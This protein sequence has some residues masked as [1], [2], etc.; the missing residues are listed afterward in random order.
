M[1]GPPLLNDIRNQS[2]SKQHM[3]SLTGLRLKTTPHDSRQRVIQHSVT[4]NL[5][6]CYYQTYSISSPL[7]LP[8]Y[9]RVKYKPI[10]L[11]RMNGKL[12]SHRSL[13]FREMLYDGTRIPS[14]WVD[15]V[16]GMRENFTVRMIDGGATRKRLR[17]VG[18]GVENRIEEFFGAPFLSVA[19]GRTCCLL[20]LALALR[21]ALSC[22]AEQQ[23]KDVVRFDTK[24]NSKHRALH[25]EYR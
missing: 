3:E 10:D 5:L 22:G 18:I 19:R 13:F 4:V 9:H 20:F 24:P 11:V 23:I 15:C 21:A 6:C 2:A 1:V 7:K 8:N 12:A 25:K 14:E 16:R 17:P